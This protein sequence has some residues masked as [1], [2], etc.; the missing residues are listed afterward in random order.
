MTFG[1]SSVRR[2]GA[3]AD[4]WTLDGTS[5][6][7][8]LKVTVVDPGARRA[9]TR[10]SKVAGPGSASGLLSAVWAA[11]AAVA[12]A[13]PF[14]AAGV[15]STRMVLRALRTWYSDGRVSDMRT[16]ASEAPSTAAACSSLTAAI[17]PSGTTLARAS[18]TLTLRRS[19]I[20]VSGSGRLTA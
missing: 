13:V 14:P 20:S 6:P 19:T 3:S 7:L 4:S 1:K 5:C 11:G 15:S 17:A 8:P 10:S 12:A 2:R 9:R 16:R 18:A